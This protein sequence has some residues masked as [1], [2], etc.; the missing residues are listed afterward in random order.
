M[1]DYTKIAAWQKADDL[2]V[3]VYQATRSFPRDEVYALTS[4]VRRASYS[5]PANIVEGASRDSKKDYLHFL[6]IARGSL[7]ETRYFL[8]LAGRLNCLTPGQQKPLIEQA[9]EAARV[10]AGLI[11]SVEAETGKLARLAARTTSIFVLG[12]TSTLLRHAFV[13]KV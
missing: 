12:L 10:L 2:T 11:R 7:A 3:A 4:Q 6:Y 9:D 1:R 8:H 13:S 5:V